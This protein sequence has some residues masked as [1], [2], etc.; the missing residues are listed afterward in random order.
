MTLTNNCKT[1]GPETISWVA[2][3]DPNTVLALL[4][5]SHQISAEYKFH[6]YSKHTFTG[7]PS[8]LLKFLDG[9][10]NRRELIRTIEVEGAEIFTANIYESL[11]PRVFYTLR[12][13]RYLRTVK[14][15]MS[16]ATFEAVQL[17]LNKLGFSQLRDKNIE[18]IIYNAYLTRRMTPRN[19]HMEMRLDRE[20]SVWRQSRGELEWHEETG[21]RESSEL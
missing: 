21:Q 15:N 18:I 14:L 2:A 9:I 1:L 11:M 10:G 3:Q 13:L 20:L 8:C 16:E 12:K 17:K 6:F 5:V 4:S 19:T 7:Q